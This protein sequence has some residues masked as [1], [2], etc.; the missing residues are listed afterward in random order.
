MEE[1]EETFSDYGPAAKAA[2]SW[3]TNGRTNGTPEAWNNQFVLYTSRL[4]PYKSQ[5]VGK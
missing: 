4:G 3:V 1:V 2:A 5:I